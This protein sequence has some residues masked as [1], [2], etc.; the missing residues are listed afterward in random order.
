MSLK[1]MSTS[2]NSIITC[3]GKHER[4]LKKK[5]QNG[6]FQI[7]KERKKKNKICKC[8][9][10]ES[11]TLNQLQLHIVTFISL[12]LVVKSVKKYIHIFQWINMLLENTKI[13]NH[14]LIPH[15]S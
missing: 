8:V 4:G 9:Y 12:H 7:Q 14:H 5:N 2:I 1:S 15:I 13:L 3:T 6:I 10:V 11:Y